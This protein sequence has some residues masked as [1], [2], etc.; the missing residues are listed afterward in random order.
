MSRLE[1]AAAHVVEEL[2][3]LG[4]TVACAESCTGGKL[5]S[6]LTSVPG[7]SRVFAGGVVVYTLEAKERLLGVSRSDLDEYG[8]G[9]RTSAMLAGRIAE[10]LDTDCGVG[11]TGFA[12]P[13]APS[14]RRVGELHVAVAVRREWDSRYDVVV[15]TPDGTDDREVN[16]MIAVGAA[17]EMMRSWLERKER[18]VSNECTQEE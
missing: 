18:R 17:L 3:R 12:G 5:A 9:P 10:L 1:S 11:V 6:L 13:G 8:V 4:L 14:P 16:R 2:A 7:A 15:R